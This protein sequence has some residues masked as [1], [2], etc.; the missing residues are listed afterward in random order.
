[1]N[2]ITERINEDFLSAPTA[3]PYDYHIFRLLFKIYNSKKN[4]DIEIK[5]LKIRYSD[6]TFFLNIFLY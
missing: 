6:Y 5:L 3:N 2:K 4:I 1:M